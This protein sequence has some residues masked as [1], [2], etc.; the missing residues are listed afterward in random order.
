[1]D[2]TIITAIISV[3][4]SILVA[5]A[6]YYFTKMRER[7]AAWRSDKLNYYKA[8]IRSVNGVLEGQN[9]KEGREEFSKAC[10][11]LLLFAPQ[12]VLEAMFKY[13]DSTK[14]GATEE[15][16][17]KHDEL[18]S[19]LMLEIRKDLGISPKDNELSFKVKLWSPGK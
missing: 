9:T 4:G 3:L 17:N 6:G 5:S 7:E 18:L 15:Q 2:A 19:K 13:L 16:S 11:D 10:D 14:T 1:M 12:N 8:F